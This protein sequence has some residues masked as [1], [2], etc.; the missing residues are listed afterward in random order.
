MSKTF[1]FFFFYSRGPQDE[2]RFSESSCL[3]RILKCINQ[4]ILFP[5]VMTLRANIYEQFPF[6]DVKGGW[7]VVVN[8]GETTCR[9]LFLNLY[10]IYYFIYYLF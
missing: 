6:K 1:I 4:E 10:F 9:F 3:V 8:L 2:P 5:A 7:N